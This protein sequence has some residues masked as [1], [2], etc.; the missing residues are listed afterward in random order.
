LEQEVSATTAPTGAAPGTIYVSDNRG[1][2][3][4]SWTLTGTFVPTAVGAGAGQNSNASCA[5]VDAFCNS[6]VGTAALNTATNGAHDGQIAPN[7]LSVAAITCAADS[8]GGITANG[9]TYNPPNLN[10]SA[11]PTAGG[12]FAAPV[13]LCSAAAGQSGGTFIY[14]A[15]YT[16]VIPES[17]YAGTYVG[18]VR[19]TVA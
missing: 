10:P 16:L 1:S 5:G 19:Y 13:N 8:T 6:S 14:N 17:V 2:P 18:S 4:D 7:Y 3:T 12:N 9:T 15:T 11:T